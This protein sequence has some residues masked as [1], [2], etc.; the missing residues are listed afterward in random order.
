[1]KSPNWD[2][3]LFTAHR[4]HIKDAEV[5][6]A[7]DYLAAIAFQTGLYIIQNSGSDG[8][9]KS[10]H[11][12]ESVSAR[13]PFAFIVNAHHLLFYI[14]LPG[15]KRFP[16]GIDFF[17]KLFTTVNENPNGEWTIRIDTL[18]D[19]KRMMQIV[20]SGDRHEGSKDWPVQRSGWSASARGLADG[21]GKRLSGAYV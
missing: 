3:G 8:Q 19:A 4:N 6:R 14:R 1:M 11:Y 16:G 20:F 2:D 18:A 17:K 10:F 9:K 12:N 21:R 5:R 7:F 15:Q 13:R